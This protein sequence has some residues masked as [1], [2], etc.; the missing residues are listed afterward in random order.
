[1]ELVKVKKGKV[2]K[3]IEKR[4]LA[5]YLSD[6]WTIAEKDNNKSQANA[7]DKPQANEEKGKN[8]GK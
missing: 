2:T 5:D 4:L 3:Q 1:M 6:G 8:N 7:E